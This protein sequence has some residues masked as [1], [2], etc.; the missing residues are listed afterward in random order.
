MVAP[1]E[2]TLEEARLAF[3]GSP[4]RLRSAAVPFRMTP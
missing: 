1:V 4:V 3:L 2:M